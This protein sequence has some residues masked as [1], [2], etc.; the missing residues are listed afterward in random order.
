MTKMRE[1]TARSENLLTGE[2]KEVTKLK[3]ANSIARGVHRLE[4][5]KDGEKVHDTE[6]ENFIAITWDDIQKRIA[7]QLFLVDRYQ[8]NGTANDNIYFD[9]G[10]LLHPN[11]MS[12]L[13]GQS[14]MGSY[15]FP[16]KAM[17]LSVY[18]APER[19]LTERA[20]FGDNLGYCFREGTYSGTDTRRGTFNGAE[21]FVE[22]KHIRF[23]YDFPTHAANG[24]IKS[25]YWAS[26][27]MNGTAFEPERIDFELPTGYVFRIDSPTSNENTYGM[28]IKGSKF[29]V[30][31]E[32][33]DG[34]EH[35]IAVF[36]IDLTNGT[37]TFD[38]ATGV[39][40]INTSYGIQDFDFHETTGDIYVKQG[41]YG[42]IYRYPSTGGDSIA[43]P[44]G[45]SYLT[46]SAHSTDDAYR[47]AFCLVG[48]I[49]YYMEHSYTTYLRAKNINDLNTELIPAITLWSG[50]EY[51]TMVSYTDYGLAISDTSRDNIYIYDDLTEGFNRT[52]QALRHMET[53]VN[54]DKLGGHLMKGSD[55]EPKYLRG[56]ADNDKS[57]GRLYIFGVGDIGGRNL[58]PTPIEKTD[59]YT[60]KVTYD[61]Y[62]E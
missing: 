19:P 42:R 16:F 59:E 57:T 62:F 14:R 32:K 48:D 18:D 34:S 31:C 10:T 41:A 22:S 25:L 3:P 46:A 44:G 15:E 35:G 54:Y 24:V 12:T 58:L 53:Y 55:G 49:I 17:Y 45:N 13:I 28:R 47:H 56:D 20:M 29:Y 52:D 9:Q 51:G 26:S 27:E 1:S 2:I 11:N 8:N 23:V 7:K 60:M 21:S 61:L 36:D 33:S 6:S 38:E 43:W 50:Y 40:P 39:I 30:S 4:L 5:F 37:I